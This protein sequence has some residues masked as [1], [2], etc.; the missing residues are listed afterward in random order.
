MSTVATSVKIAM[1][2]QITN[3]SRLST[4]SPCSEATSGSQSIRSATATQMPPTTIAMIVSG[5]V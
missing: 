4:R 2:A 3:Q 1:E 5:T